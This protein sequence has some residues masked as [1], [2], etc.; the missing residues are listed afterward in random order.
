[1]RCLSTTWYNRVRHKINKQIPIRNRLFLLLNRRRSRWLLI[2]IMIKWPTIKSNKNSKRSLLKKIINRRLLQIIRPQHNMPEIEKERKKD[3][4]E[5]SNFLNQIFFPNYSQAEKTKPPKEP[6]HLS[7]K[8]PLIRLK[9]RPQN[10]HK[11]KKRK[12]KRRNVMS[13]SKMMTTNSVWKT[14]ASMMN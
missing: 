9:R 5:R 8:P 12:S 7:T 13:K 10:Q 2:I 6:T 3:W 4:S 11:N 1:M 14:L